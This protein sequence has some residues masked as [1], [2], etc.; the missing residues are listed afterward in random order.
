MGVEPQGKTST[1]LLMGVEPQGKT[2][3]VA[4]AKALR[5]KAVAVKVEVVLVALVV[6]VPV[7][8]VTWLVPRQAS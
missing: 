3:W 6:L 2:C 1:F 7:V 8:E 4:L 5:P